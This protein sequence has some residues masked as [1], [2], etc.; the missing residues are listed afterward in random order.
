MDNMDL[1]KI[2]QKGK[3]ESDAFFSR[4]DHAQARNALKQR[5]S[6]NTIRKEKPV[7][8]RALKFGFSAAIVLLIA[9][10]S[11][12][13][14]LETSQGSKSLESVALSSQPVSLDDGGNYFL[15]YFP[16]TPP[17]RS[18][19]G[20]MS[21]LWQLNN[22]S[23]DIAYSTLFEKCDEAYPAS[24]V[25]FPDKNRK[26]V[27]IYSGDNDE[28]F[29]DY[30][31]IGYSGGS[32]NVWWSQDFVNGGTLDVKNGVVV[33]RRE[34]GLS[35]A[36]VSYIV[37]YD[38]KSNGELLLPVESLQIRVG[39]MVMLVGSGLKTLEVSSEN[40]LFEQT[41]QT[42]DI[43][44]GTEALAYRA[45]QAGSDVLRLIDLDIYRGY[46]NINVVE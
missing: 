41:E 36:E 13:V 15:N 34:D 43:Y 21:V 30:R 22:K 5:I 26:L 42:G 38:V 40:G 2:L 11:L 25:V 18:E 8:P 46:L 23:S 10:V 1:E 17:G 16:V 9:A 19:P 6:H 29:I 32:V 27:L 28:H 35:P 12:A 31:L 45:K 20:I 37:P 39:E 24:D 33:E 14:I 4:I 44:G 3:T 7:W